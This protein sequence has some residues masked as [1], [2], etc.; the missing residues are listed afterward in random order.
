MGEE[1]EGEMWRVEGGGGG[2]EMERG[3]DSGKGEV[4]EEVRWRRRGRERCGGWG[5]KGVK[6]K[7]VR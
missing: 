6:W 3:R 1:G 2:G 4:K 7:E 5:E